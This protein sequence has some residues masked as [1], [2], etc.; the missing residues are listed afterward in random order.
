MLI[1][2]DTQRKNL[3]LFSS[4]KARKDERIRFTFFF[5]LRIKAGKIPRN[6]KIYAV[7]DL[8]IGCA[9]HFRYIPYVRVVER[10][11]SGFQQLC[12]RLLYLFACG[13]RFSGI[14][15]RLHSKQHI[16][17]KCVQQVFCDRSDSMT[18]LA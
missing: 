18:D 12:L 1:I 10:C 5:L 7:D 14:L 2:D 17:I 6:Q 9:A 3:I 16:F 13:D 15:L 8:V 4:I 11:N